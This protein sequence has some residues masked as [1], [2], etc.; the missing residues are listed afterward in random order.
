MNYS[1]LASSYVRRPT[2]NFDEY[3]VPALLLTSLI[4]ML[5][6]FSKYLRKRESKKLFFSAQSIL[7]ATSILWCLVHFPIVTPE[8][9]LIEPAFYFLIP[10]FFIPLITIMK[11]FCSRNSN[12]WLFWSSLSIL[13]AFILL[14]L[15]A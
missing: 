4:L 2:A 15:S 8:N 9:G 11:H 1:Q 13:I 10:I 6:G 7:A 12:R 14:F 3:L 5:I